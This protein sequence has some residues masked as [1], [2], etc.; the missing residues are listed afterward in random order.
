MSADDLF[1]IDVTQ[2]GSSGRVSVTGELD[3][4]SS[5]Q[6]REAV[7]RQR[8][9]HS[10]VILDV[11][12]VT[13]MDSSGLTMLQQVSADARSGG[14]SFGIAGAHESAGVERVTSLAS[15]WDDLELR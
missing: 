11:S 4:K 1:S 3:I 15:A 5:L 9:R 8:E 12:G 7:D 2:D 13:F 14:W 10:H 6:A